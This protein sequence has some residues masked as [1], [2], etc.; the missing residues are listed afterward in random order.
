MN[1]ENNYYF[2]YGFREMGAETPPVVQN[3]FQF[4]LRLQQNKL[5]CLSLQ[6]LSS[7]V[8]YL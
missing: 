4:E 2:T 8:K 3:R 1:Q 7:Q 6:N 5:E